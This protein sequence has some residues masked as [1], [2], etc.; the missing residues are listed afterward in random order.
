MGSPSAS[1]VMV[2]DRPLGLPLF[3]ICPPPPRVC[4]TIRDNYIHVE[5]A[6]DSRAC[7]V[8]WG[9]LDGVSR[10]SF[11]ISIGLELLPVGALRWLG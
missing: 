1:G 11:E 10:A 9:R 5:D 3:T 8:I 7:C 4:P 2:S 6:P